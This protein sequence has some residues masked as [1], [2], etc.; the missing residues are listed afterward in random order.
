[1]YA[2]FIGKASGFDRIPLIGVTV[3]ND[4]ATDLFVDASMKAVDLID[5]DAACCAV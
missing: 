5:A 2:A 1:M 4:V 3:P